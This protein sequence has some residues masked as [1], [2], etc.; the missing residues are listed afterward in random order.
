MK[1]NLELKTRCGDL[2][3]AKERLRAIGAKEQVGMQQVDT[4][5]NVAHGRLKLREMEA[6][7]ELIWYRREDSAVTRGSDYLIVPVSDARV[8]KAALAG[9]MGVRVVVKKRR[10]WFLWEN[11]RVHLDRV[12]GLGTF[13]EFEAVMENGETE[14]KGHERIAWLCKE[15]GIEA[16]DRVEGSYSDLL[17]RRPS[18]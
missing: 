8:M 18:P 9:A 2:E 6:R 3:G 14:E 15:L 10:E 12:E 7:A 13:V 5:F 11:V 16:G 17:L 4:Y 1:R